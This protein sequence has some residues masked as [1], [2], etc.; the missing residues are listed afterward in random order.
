MHKIELI[1]GAMGSEFIR[2]GITLPKHWSNM[3]SGS[4]NEIKGWTPFIGDTNGA[5][6]TRFKFQLVEPP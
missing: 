4:T 3:M 6:S 5:Q 2:T 1:D